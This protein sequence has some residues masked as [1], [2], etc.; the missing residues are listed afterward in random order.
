[1]REIVR[2]ADSAAIVVAVIALAH[3]LGLL[4]IAEG[5]ETEAQLNFLRA[6][7]CNEMQGYYFSKPLPVAG[8]E[9]LLREKRKLAF[10]AILQ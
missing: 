2:N 4:A 7:D 8:F 5:V 1:M 6:H 9:Q 3:G 10:T